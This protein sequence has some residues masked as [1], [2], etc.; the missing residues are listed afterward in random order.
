M[1]KGFD[2]SIL[3]YSSVSAITSL[4]LRERNIEH[5]FRIKKFDS[6]FDKFPP[7]SNPLVNRNTQ[8]LEK[9][10]ILPVLKSIQ[11]IKGYDFRW[12][13]HNFNM[14]MHLKGK[15]KFPLYAIDNRI[16]YKYLFNGISDEKNINLIEFDSDEKL[17]ENLSSKVNIVG[18]ETYLT[19]MF[20]ENIMFPKNS[21]SIKRELFYV[22]L[23]ASQSSLSKIKF[24]TSLFIAEFGYIFIYPTLHLNGKNGL[25]VVVNLINNN[26]VVEPNSVSQ[27][28]SEAL[29]VIKGHDIFLYNELKKCEVIK[30]N[31]RSVDLQPCFNNPVYLKNGTYFMGVGDVIA[32]NDPITGQG[33]NSGLNIANKLVEL[34]YDDKK[35]FNS[36]LEEY[37]VYSNQMLDYL[38]HINL[39]FTQNKYLSSVV[40][41]FM[42]AMENK[43]LRNFIIGETYEDISLYF[44]WLN[45]ENENEKLNSYFQYKSI[46]EK[47]LTHFKLNDSFYKK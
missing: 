37:E 36:I 26:I 2:I 15:Y 32:K 44:P 34:I 25:T 9:N 14:T 20:T 45:N 35:N 47:L 41:T 19:P 3:G 7:I 27:K 10:Y 13:D 8:I 28:W 31:Y 40:P 33:L 22:N 23:I 1:K 29:D 21:F 12:Y 6:S 43:R 18:G 39:A 11:W 24:S 17:V 16:R 30:E 4:L 46:L 5:T 42:N 38:Y